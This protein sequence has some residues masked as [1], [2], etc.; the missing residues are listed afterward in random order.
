[1]NAGRPM[2]LLQKSIGAQVL[3]ELRG[4]RKLRGRLRGYD[5]HLNLILEDADEMSFDDESEHEIIEVIKTV[6]VRGDN[7]VLVSPPPKSARE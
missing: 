1:M 2:D 5:Q 3:V 6:I 7:I 4:K